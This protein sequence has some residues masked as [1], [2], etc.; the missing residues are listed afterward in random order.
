[1]NRHIEVVH[2]GKRPYKC[3]TCG[4]DF[5]MSGNL[6]KH[7]KAHERKKLQ[8]KVIKPWACDLCD[9][10]FGEK[11]KLKR[12]TESV[13]EGKKPFSCAFCD[14]RFSQ[15]KGLESHVDS[16]HEEKKQ[17]KCGSCDKWFAFKHN[18][19]RHIKY[20]H[21]K[22]KPFSCPKA[23]VTK[24]DC[25]S[26]F[27]KKENVILFAFAYGAVKTFAQSSLGAGLANICRNHEFPICTTQLHPTAF[28]KLFL[29][30]V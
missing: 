9:A 26:T 8:P 2:E 23:D 22:E 28:S 10:S 4:K 16:V 14:S 1:M 3:L 17:F 12:H 6:K 5:S 18:L 15:K 24:V 7:V 13:H 27:V 29:V 11:G 30:R 21:E 25:D 20:V 19:N